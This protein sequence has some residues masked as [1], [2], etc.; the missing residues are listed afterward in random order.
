M[1]VK[2]IDLSL[3]RANMI[4]N[5]KRQNV[6]YNGVNC[7]AHALNISLLPEALHLNLYNVGCFSFKNTRHLKTKDVIENLKS[8]LEA[9]KIKYK[10]SIPMFSLVKDDSWKIAVF[11]KQNKN[12]SLEER[13]DQTGGPNEVRDIHFVKMQDKEC[14]SKFGYNKPETNNSYKQIKKEMK[15]KGYQYVK[16]YKLTMK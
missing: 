12:C 3:V 1:E 13:L 2:N 4:V 5:R 7:Y 8:D 16:T 10:K 9:L 6:N 11:V 15:Q 14:F